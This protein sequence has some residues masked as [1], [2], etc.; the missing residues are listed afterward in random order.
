MSTD[1]AE[2]L[3]AAR[4]L[5]RELDAKLAVLDRKLWGLDEQIKAAAQGSGRVALAQVL[6]GSAAFEEHARVAGERAVKREGLARARPQLEALIA[7]VDNRIAALQELACAEAAVAETPTIAQAAQNV[8]RLAA[9][10]AEQVKIVLAAGFNRADIEESFQAAGL[11][12]PLVALG[13]AL[14][15]RHRPMIER[16]DEVRDGRGEPRVVRRFEQPPL[17]NAVDLAKL[18][19]DGRRYTLT[20]C[21][22]AVEQPMTTLNVQA[23]ITAVDRLTG[24]LAAMGAKVAGL[25]SRFAGAAAAASGFG[26]NAG[27]AAGGLIYALTSGQKELDAALRQFQVVGNATDKQRQQMRGMANELGVHLGM[28]HLELIQGATEMLQAGLST[29]DLFGKSKDNISLLQSM[30]EAAK[31]AGQPISELATDLVT[32]ARSFNMPW[33]SAS[34]RGQA[35]RDLMGLALVA[36]RLSPDTPAEHIRG[37]KEFGP[38]ASQLGMKPIEASALQSLLS[39]AGFRGSLGGM[40]MKT[41]LQRL[42]NP[43]LASQVAMS[44]KGFNYGSVMRNNL[45]DLSVDKFLGAMD[46]A[47]FD[48]GDARGEIGRALA[49]AQVKGASLDV[50]KWKADLTKRI[51]KATGVKKSDAWASRTIKQ[52]VDD[53]VA[54]TGTGMDVRAWLGELAKM[55]VSTFKDLAGLHHASKA[56]VLGFQDS[57]GEYDRLLGELERQ[58]HTALEEGFRAKAEGWAY[59]LDRMGAAWQTFRNKM[60]D[61]GGAGAWTSAVQGISG[62]LESLS[63]MKP[64]QLEALSSGL[65]KVALGLSGLAVGAGGVWVLSK[66]G[67]I[68]TGGPLGKLVLAGGLAAIFGDNLRTAQMGANGAIVGGAAPLGELMRSSQSLAESFSGLLG[69]M[70]EFAKAEFKIGWAEALVATL[71]TITSL[72]NGAA[73]AMDRLQGKTTSRSDPVM[74]AFKDSPMGAWMFPPAPGTTPVERY[75]AAD[76][77]RALRGST[78]FWDML[79]AGTMPGA[80]PVAPLGLAGAAPPAAPPQ[81]VQLEGSG[82]VTVNVKVEGPGTI[83]GVS[84]ADDGKNIKLKTGGGMG[85]TNK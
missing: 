32:L 52:N 50:L 2:Q 82:T 44:T 13:I 15:D 67:Q 61:S 83:T 77:G 64:G 12:Q 1:T 72:L 68:L 81:K 84:A 24:P 19:V 28:P 14:A 70:N 78:D 65:T 57:L 11:A 54:S 21:Q 46:A 30:G 6:G 20:R 4:E 27:I 59:A 53:L 8:H 34:A 10:L 49:E 79:K 51:A 76:G 58:R 37:L 48:A 80:G 39:S 45:G 60:W 18:M 16:Q 41:I 69:S 26:M 38:I 40:G 3:K 33:G 74:D 25:Q 17:R 5:R 31:V 43:T 23:V 47:G 56:A 9:E 42:L 63:A 73:A 29:E 62:A 85:D 22:Q 66:L 7:I 71:T 35:I 55:P 36:P 75:G